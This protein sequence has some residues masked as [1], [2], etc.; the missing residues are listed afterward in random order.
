MGR[1]YV[2]ET[3]VCM[4]SQILTDTVVILV[5]MVSFIPRVGD[6]IGERI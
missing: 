2:K 4:F 3:G 5:V 6:F 1:K